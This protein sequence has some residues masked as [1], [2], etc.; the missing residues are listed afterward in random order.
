[1]TTYTRKNRGTCARSTT[2][3]LEGEVIK[4]VVFENGCDGNLKAVS[5]LVAGMTAGEAIAKLEGI[6]CGMKGTSCPDQLAKALR[7]M[8][9]RARVSAD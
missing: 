5:R 9:D 2:V 4:E 1:M 3:T 7:E 6:R 8:L